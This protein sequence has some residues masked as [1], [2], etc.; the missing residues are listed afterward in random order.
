[1]PKADTVYAYAAGLLDGEGC[2]AV[3]ARPKNQFIPMVVLT[4]TN[5]A[6]VKWMADTFEGEV[7]SYP[8]DSV[9]EDRHTWRNSSRKQLK[10]IIPPLLPYLITKKLHAMLVLEFC[11]NYTKK[12]EEALE[13]MFQYTKLST[14]LNSRGAGSAELKNEWIERVLGKIYTQS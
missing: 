3:Y 6:A 4:M 11:N 7:L 13:R 2:F 14:I 10:E 9:R 12:D 5:K 1:M 8:G